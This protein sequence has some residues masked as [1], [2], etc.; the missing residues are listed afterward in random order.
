M[1]VFARPS[2]FGVHGVSIESCSSSTMDALLP[3]C[4]SSCGWSR[5]RGEPFCFSSK[6]A[7]WWFFVTICLSSDAA[8]GGLL[9]FLSFTVVCSEAC[10]ED[11]L[12]RCCCWRL[13]QERGLSLLAM[14]LVFGLLVLAL[15]ALGLPTVFVMARPL[16][17]LV[18]CCGTSRLVAAVVGGA[19]ADVR[20]LEAA[21]DDLQQ[22]SSTVS[23]ISVFT[24]I[25]TPPLS[26]SFI[27]KQVKQSKTLARLDQ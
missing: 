18:L 1:A 13:F 9:S 14:L 25:C 16:V 19:S 5:W 23:S 12:F 3:S 24:N 20:R 4:V 27:Q 8:L 22:L 10:G 21:R 17:A 15:R 7:C 26:D 2:D 11:A 6:I